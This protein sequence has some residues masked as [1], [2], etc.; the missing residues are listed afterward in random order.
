M[1][2]FLEVCAEENEAADMEHQMAG[3]FEWSLLSS[4]WRS[5][6]EE[7]ATAIS[8]IVAKSLQGLVFE[9]SCAF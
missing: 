3:F 8:Q 5:R 6:R 7:N 2:L 1:F 4:S 9:K